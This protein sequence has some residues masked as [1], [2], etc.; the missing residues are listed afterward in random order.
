[1]S[2][3]HASSQDDS[4]DLSR[5]LDNAL[6]DFGKARATTDDDLDTMMGH[7]D[8]EAT[9]RAAQKFQ[10]MLEQMMQ[11]PNEAREAAVEGGDSEFSAA[12]NQFMAKSEGVIN[13]KDEASFLEAFHQL[14]NDTNPGMDGLMEM[15][16]RTSLSR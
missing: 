13:A 3:P 4:S 16:I 15:I 9:Q 11:T 1:M 2:G 5:L 6:A 12:I 8:Q 7:L 14:D 10:N